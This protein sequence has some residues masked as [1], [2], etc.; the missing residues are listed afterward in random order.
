MLSRGG[1]IQSRVTVMLTPTLFLVP[2]V[3]VEEEEDSS[4]VLHVGRWT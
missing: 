3:V 2:E 4:H 1:S